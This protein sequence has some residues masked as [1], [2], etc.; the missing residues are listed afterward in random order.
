MLDFIIYLIFTFSLSILLCNLL[1]RILN[2]E[3][4]FRDYIKSLQ[5]LNKDFS[6]IIKESLDN[7][8]LNGSKFIVV[9]L[10]YLL[11]YIIS[12]YVFQRIIDNKFL[13]MLLPS[14]PYIYFL[15]RKK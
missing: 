6:N 7:I 12:F 10:F 14:L 13:L 4:Y 9:I 5:R 15:K 1:Q 3:K 2:I 8:S 11:P